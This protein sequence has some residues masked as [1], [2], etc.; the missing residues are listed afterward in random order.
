MKNLY[1]LP[2]YVIS[3]GVL[4]FTLILLAASVIGCVPSA[5]TRETGER[6]GGIP[7]YSID[8][9]AIVKNTYKFKIEKVYCTDKLT[10][11]G[12]MQTTPQAQFLVIQASI[13]NLLKRPIV[14]GNI[15]IG[16]EVYLQFK[17]VSDEGA[18]YA[19]AVTY[20]GLATK[21]AAGVSINPNLSVSGDIVFDAPPGKYTLLAVQQTLVQSY[22]YTLEDLFKYRPIECPAVQK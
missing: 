7:T 4:S 12:V 19:E 11:G 10:V 16:D 14:F 15:A 9:E 2:A 22:R 20:S 5:T 17:L 13:T 3:L 21:I 18:E 1:R 6:I 8:Q